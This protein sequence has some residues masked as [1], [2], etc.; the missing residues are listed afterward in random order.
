M[1]VYFISSTKGSISYYAE[2]RKHYK[3]LLSDMKMPRIN[4]LLGT[5][6]CRWGQAPSGP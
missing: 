6:L 3:F 5:N 1:M 2:I 4:M